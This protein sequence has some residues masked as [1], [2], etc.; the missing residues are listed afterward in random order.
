MEVVRASAR[1]QVAIPRR[2]REELGIREGDACQAEMREGGEGGWRRWRGLP[3]GMGALEGPLA[4][5]RREV[6]GEGGRP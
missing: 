3:A 5:H 4:E 2:V 6:G 1:G